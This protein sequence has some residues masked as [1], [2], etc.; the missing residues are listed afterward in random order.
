[1]CTTGKGIM[2]YLSEM[3]RYEILREGRINPEAP[4]ADARINM[5]IR[6]DHLCVRLMK[7]THAFLT[8]QGIKRVILL[9]VSDYQENRLISVIEK[10]LTGRTYPEIINKNHG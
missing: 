9:S 6:D 1:M 2:T 8:T 5:V 10:A 7:T 3:A 4:N